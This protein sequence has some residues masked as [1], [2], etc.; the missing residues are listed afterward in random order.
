MYIKWYY[1]ISWGKEKLMTEAPFKIVA[2][3]GDDKTCKTTLALSFPKPMY[4]AEFDIGG[5]NRAVNQ[6]S[7]GNKLFHW[8][9]QIAKGDIKVSKFTV[10]FQIDT[11]LPIGDRTIKQPKR[12]VGM[13]EM[14]Y[15]FLREYMDALDDPNITTIVLDTGTLLWELTTACYLQ[16]LQE[17]QFGP[18]GVLMVGQ[19]LRAQLIQIE[20]K[21]PNTRMR[22]LIYQAKARD[23]FLIITHHSSDE[24]GMVMKDGML[25]QGPTGKKKLHGWQSIGD[26]ADLIVQTLLKKVET[27]SDPNQSIKKLLPFCKVD[28]TSVFTMKDMEIQEPTYDKLVSV[29]DMVSG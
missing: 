18:N 11:T 19:Q 13:K 17:K 3:W 27:S 20:Y 22:A 28:L 25:Q 21:E 16:E 2:I 9:D 26:G 5:F 10:P 24:Y 6:I 14:Y 23:K 12:V 8:Q 29:M 1:Q 15:T 4:V 7:V